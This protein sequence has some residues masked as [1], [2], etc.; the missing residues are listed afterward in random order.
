MLLWPRRGWTERI[1][2]G[3][4]QAKRIN[5]ESLAMNVTTDAGC[6]SSQR[7][8]W[9]RREGRTSVKL[10]LHLFKNG[11][12]A[13]RSLPRFDRRGG[14]NE[15]HSFIE[16]IAGAQGFLGWW[17]GR[18]GE[19]KTVAKYR[20]DTEV[21]RTVFRNCFDTEVVRTGGGSRAGA[22][23]AVSILDR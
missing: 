13:A 16:H 8:A 20:F 7:H 11:S 14:R 3:S 18:W 2:Q 19:I 22:C 12:D 15:F 10:A 23:A 17:V 5:L 6:D 1:Q 9:Q 21:V 4:E